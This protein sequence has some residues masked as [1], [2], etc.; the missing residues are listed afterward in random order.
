[1][2]QLKTNK[3]DSIALANHAKEMTSKLFDALQAGNDLDSLKP[4][5]EELYKWVPFP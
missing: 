3:E 5:I 1:M 2:Q 4:S